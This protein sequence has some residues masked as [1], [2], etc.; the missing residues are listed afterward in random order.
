MIERKN[1]F[2]HKTLKNPKKKTL[3]KCRN[4]IQLANITLAPKPLTKII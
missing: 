4:I 3:F 1:N 2:N